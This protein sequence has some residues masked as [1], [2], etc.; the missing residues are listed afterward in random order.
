MKLLRLV[1]ILTVGLRYG[2]EE[3]FLGH[4]RV[5]PLRWLVRAT[6]FWRPLAEPRGVRLRR[7]LEALGPIF[8][9]FGQMLSTRRDLVPLDIAD[10]LA[11]LQDRVPPFPSAE[12]IATLEAA[13]KKP[14]AEVFAEFD[15]TPVA[16]ASVAQVHFA[17]L[18][19]RTAVAVK[20]LR[21][22]IAPVI[23]H[24]VSL[25]YAAA[26]L[27]EKLFADGKRLRP[28]EVVAE[29]E[30]HLEDELDLMREAANC[31]QLRRNFKDSPLLLVPEVYW[32]YCGRDVMVM[33]RMDGI[34]VSRIERLRESGVNL[35]RLA[36]A[37][38]EIFFTQVFRDGFFHAD[39]HPGNILVRPGSNPDEA[40]NQSTKP[41][42]GQVAGYLPQAGEGANAGPKPIDQYIALDFG[43]MGTLTEVDKQYLARNFLA[44]FRRD[45]KGVALAHLE[46]GWVPPD[47]R[48]DELEAAVRAVCEPVFDR[49]LKEISFG[50][51]LLQLFQASRRFNVEIQ[52]QLVLLQKTL[53]NIEGLGRQLDPDLDLWKTAKPF[54]ERWMNEQVGWRALVKNLQ[55]EAPKW[56]A[57]LPQLPR[58]AHQALN[59]NRLTQL[60]AGL[61][62]MLRQQ[63]VRN[64]WLGVIAGLLAALAA[65]VILYSALH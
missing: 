38:V 54:L 41:A 53:L 9:K 28:R 2:L 13:Y 17:R 15:A 25:L 35:P 45:Y 65:A 46:S 42:S 34:P 31:S 16:S 47:T 59:E 64:R 40:T 11:L 5:R 48:I 6:L 4:E 30:K 3:F 39:M 56:A 33:D 7:A 26:G 61:A 1:R 8:V 44:F 43:I 51:V 32:D 55:T 57:L 63:H 27:V 10:E 36:A 49:P 62:L 29:F 37:G 14:L 23:A 12:A 50:R 19:D 24:D 21:P 22:G 18:H 60:E 52:P 58:L 20:V